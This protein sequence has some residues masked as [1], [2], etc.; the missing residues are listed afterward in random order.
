MK[1]IKFVDFNGKG[2]YSAP[3]FVWEKSIGPTAL[4]FL[5]SDKLGAEI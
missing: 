1:N 4:T 3:E 2:K 5:A